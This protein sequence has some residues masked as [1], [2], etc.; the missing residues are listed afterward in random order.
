MSKRQSPRGNLRRRLSAYSLAAGA[1][2]LTGAAADLPAYVAYYDN[3]GAGWFDS[4]AHFGGTAG[5]YDMILFALDGTVLVDDA[6]IDPALPVG[7]SIEIKGESYNGQYTWGDGKSR[8]SAYLRTYNAGVVGTYWNSSPEAVKLGYGATVGPSST[9]VTGTVGLYGYGW[10]SVVGGFGGRG[11]MGF[12]IDDDQGGRHYG[13]AD[14]HVNSARNEI[15]LHSFAV[16]TV[17]DVPIGGILTYP[18]GDFDKDLDVDAADVDAIYDYMANGSG[19]QDELFDVDLDGD[20][21]EDDVAHLIQHLVEI[22]L[23]GDGTVD[24]LGSF[25]GD[26]NFDGLVN[27][28]DLSIMSGNFG[29]AVGYAGGNANGD[30]AVN[31][32]D[33]SLL[34]S[35][36]GSAVTHAIPEPMTL[37]LLALGVGGLAAHRRRS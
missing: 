1:A 7:S 17:A 13:W 28:T 3:Y 31:G 9:F 25:R 27:G 26:F 15:T 14:L 29:Q 30:G 11:Y 23:D 4:R 37:S 35:T 12:Y 18:P 19:L 36:F 21:D 16:Q 22:D 20:V 32:T 10:Y 8:D 33:L 24:R 2:A 5:G 6:Q 34:S